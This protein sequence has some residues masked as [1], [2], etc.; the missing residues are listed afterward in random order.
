[1]Y[2]KTIILDNEKLRKLLKEKG[3][4]IN[5]G[6]LVSDEIVEKENKLEEIDKE[7][8][9]IEKSV[10]ISDLKEGAEKIT[11][12]FNAL[13]KRMEEAKQKMFDRLKQHTEPK[14][15]EYEVLKKEKEKLETKRNKIALKAQ[16][17]NDK[18]IPLG[19][20]LMAEHITDEFEDYDSIRIEGDQIVSTIFSHLEDFKEQYRKNKSLKK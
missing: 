19:R 18:I 11:D 3:D 1:M 7:I 20:K 10:D 2:P 8:Q 9:D 14:V 13:I 17:K 4:L 16:Q 15:K 12:E 5:E 6:R